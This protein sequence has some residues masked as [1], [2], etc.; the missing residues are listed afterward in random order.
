MEK[1]KSDN[2]PTNE[3]EI[4]AKM[5]EAA[6]AVMAK[7]YLGDGVYDLSEATII[8]LCKSIQL[9]KP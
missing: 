9:S 8:E 3:V 5:I 1:E 7:H 6:T 4:S 2:N